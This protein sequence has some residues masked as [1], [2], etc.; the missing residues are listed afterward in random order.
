MKKHT[1]TLLLGL[2]LSLALGGA[3]QAQDQ[4]PAGPAMMMR[5]HPPA[6]PARQAQRLAKTLDLTP[7]QVGRIEPI[8]RDRQQ[9]LEALRNG[10]ANG[11]D[12]H[13]RMR[14][15]MESHNS[16]IEAVLTASQRQKYEQLRQQ[17]QQRR[18]GGR[19]GDGN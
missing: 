4:P 13:D 6:D 10:A 19:D 8:L 17:R 9:Q 5:A 11:Q 15:I 3:A 14:Q 12:R 1:R 2:G 18:M 16:Q 7:D